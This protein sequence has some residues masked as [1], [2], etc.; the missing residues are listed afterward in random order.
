[1]DNRGGAGG[2]IGA[3]I[4]AKSPPDGYTLFVGPIGTMAIN[5]FVYAKMPFDS[6]KDFA[7]ISQLTSIPIV[8]AV[9]PSV[10]A[11]DVREFI[12]FAKANPGKV[13]F[14]SGGN[15]TQS[16]ISG[17]MLN[18]LAGIDMTHI[19]YKG[20]GPAMVDLLAGRVSVMF[21]QI[22]SALPHI[23]AGKLNAIG[24]TTAKRSA[25][26]PDIPTLAETGLP[27]FE[28]TT[29]HG[30]LAPA[31]TPPDVVAKLNAETVK[32]LKSPELIEKFKTNGI[33]PVSSSPE[34]FAALIKSEL[35]RWG[36]V[37]KAAGLKPE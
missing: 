36:D 31:G 24:V 12:A 2:N 35:Q 23:R 37:V 4:V 13:N 5:P 33:D 19:P 3:E 28:A 22:S 21:D 30:L 10:P 15:G 11:K 9:H 25:V 6:V 14:G 1:V 32:A 7:P 26:A 18:S 17:V 16:H 8:M 29:W 20:N 34:Q 27:T